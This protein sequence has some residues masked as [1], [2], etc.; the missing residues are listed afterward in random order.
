M[1]P[2]F[3][4]FLVELLG[5][6][7]IHIEDGSGRITETGPARSRVDYRSKAERHVGGVEIGGQAFAVRCGFILE[8]SALRWQYG[9]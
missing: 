8:P 1:L 4:I 7:S 5:T 3:H 2:V 6:G 9:A